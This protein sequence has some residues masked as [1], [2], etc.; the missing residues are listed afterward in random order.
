VLINQLEIG[1]VE[2]K[3]DTAELQISV[4]VLGHDKLQQQALIV[5]FN[6]TPEFW[7]LRFQSFRRQGSTQPRRATAPQAH[8][9]SDFCVK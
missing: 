2:G 3:E 1:V 5:S 6:W 8:V 4:E 7:I 9:L